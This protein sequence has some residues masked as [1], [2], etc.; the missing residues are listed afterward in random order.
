M[1]PLERVNGLSNLFS[2]PLV[3]LLIP[4]R[5]GKY[6]FKLFRKNTGSDLP[7]NKSKL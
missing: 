6:T 2:G 3:H 1:I 4:L 7:E 5:K